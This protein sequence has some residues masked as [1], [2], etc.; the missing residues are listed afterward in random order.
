MLGRV[1]GM[2]TANAVW[3]HPFAALVVGFVWLLVLVVFGLVFMGMY[4]CYVIAV[5]ARW[6]YGRWVTRYQGTHRSVS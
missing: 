4:A 2:G 3:N 6:G 1:G 5:G